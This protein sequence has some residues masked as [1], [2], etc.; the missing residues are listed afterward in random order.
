GS[1]VSP[2]LLPYCPP[3]ARIVA[4][5]PMSLAE[6]EAEYLRAAAAGQDVAR[7]HSGD[8]SV[9]SAVDEQVRRLQKHGIDYTMTPGVPAFAD[10]ASTLG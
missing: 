10:A 7:L 3:G 2:E 5:A 6:I 4:T 8:L 1:I 9:W